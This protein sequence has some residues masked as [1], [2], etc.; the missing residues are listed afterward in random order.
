[1]INLILSL[2]LLTHA[3]QLL[4]AQG[5]SEFRAVGRPS[6]I[7]IVGH[8]QGPSGDFNWTKEGTDYVI[9]GESLL[10]LDTLDTG[11]SLRDQH[12]KEKYLETGK[13]KTANL[14]L[15]EIRV[16]SDLIH[17]GGEFKTPGI[18]NLKGV[19][20]SVE[21]SVSIK[22]N[23][24]KLAIQSQFQIKLSD[25]SVNIPS[26]MGITVADL[27]D[28]KIETAIDTKLFDLEKKAK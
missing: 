9:T 18:L 13:I 4:P 11:I 16:S 14:K 26:Y 12:M 1:M 25:F 8:G 23:K 7:K 3:H 17:Q 19:E 28:I 24:E 21:V 27:V 5:S 15:K 6:A 10:D 20:K 2:S 22:P